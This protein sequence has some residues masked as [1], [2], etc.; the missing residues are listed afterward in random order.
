MYTVEASVVCRP[1]VA[2]GVLRVQDAVYIEVHRGQ[3][4]VCSADLTGYAGSAAIKVLDHFSSRVELTFK[5]L[6]LCLVFHLPAESFEQAWRCIDAL[7]ALNT[8]RRYGLARK[9]VSGEI[10]VDEF[11]QKHVPRVLAELTVDELMS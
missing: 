11:L 2:C 7:C 9:L 5:R 4:H 6:P 10:P 8:K 1:I 3:Q